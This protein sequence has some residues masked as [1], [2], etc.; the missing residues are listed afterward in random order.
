M[1]DIILLAVHTEKAPTL[2]RLLRVVRCKCRAS[3]KLL[4]ALV[5]NMALMCGECREICRLNSIQMDSMTGNEDS[6]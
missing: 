6:D 1:K 3:C 2:D 5:V 4:V